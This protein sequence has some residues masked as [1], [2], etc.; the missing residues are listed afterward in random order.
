MNSNID[1]STIIDYLYGEM[2]EDEKLL[3]EKQVK[4]SKAKP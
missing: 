2:N 1:K 4:R 3:F